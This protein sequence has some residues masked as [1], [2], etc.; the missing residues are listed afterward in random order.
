MPCSALYYATCPV[1]IWETLS[2][3]S[4][5]SEQEPRKLNDFSSSFSLEKT[6]GDAP[7]S[8]KW[9]DRHRHVYLDAV[10]VLRFL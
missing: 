5:F 6:L 9:H 10:V 7:L 8:K 4:Q 1:N 3:I 2:D